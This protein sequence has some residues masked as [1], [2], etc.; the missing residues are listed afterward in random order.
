MGLFRKMP[1][2]PRVPC[3]HPTLSFKMGPCLPEETKANRGNKRSYKTGQPRPEKEGLGGPG[4]GEAAFICG[5]IVGREDRKRQS[6]AGRGR[7]GHLELGAA[8]RL[9]RK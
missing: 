5:A 7:K 8:S 3:P 4:A 2:N 6:A 9:S 1:T